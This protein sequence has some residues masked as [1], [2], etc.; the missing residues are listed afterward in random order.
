MQTDLNHFYF[1]GVETNL[2]VLKIYGKNLK[3]NTR[4][5]GYPFRCIKTKVISAIIFFLFLNFSMCVVCRL[6]YWFEVTLEIA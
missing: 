3:L 5:H 1:V 2:L 6:Y 4:K